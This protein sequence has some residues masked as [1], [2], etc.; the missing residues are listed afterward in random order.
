MGNPGGLGVRAYAL[1]WERPRKR[2]REGR[3]RPPLGAAGL[4]LVSRPQGARGH[5]KSKKA[6]LSC[7]TCHETRTPEPG[8]AIDS[9]PRVFR[10]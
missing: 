2:A 8:K 10:G 1:A 4:G 6:H 9:I 3:E 7:P 5:P